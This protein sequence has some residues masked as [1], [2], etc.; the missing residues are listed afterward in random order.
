MPLLNDNVMQGR[1][2]R[3]WLTLSFAVMFTAVFLFNSRV[4]MLNVVDFLFFLPSLTL[5]TRA[6]V[7]G[8]HRLLSS[9][10][11]IPLYALLGWALLSMAWAED[12]NGS[13]TVRAVVQIIAM[14]GLF[15]WLHLY[16]R[17]TFKQ[18]LTNGALCAVIVAATVM[19]SYY[20]TQ[21]LSSPLFSEPANLIFHL[22]SLDPPSALMAMLAP[23]FILLAQAREEGPSGK[24]GRRLAGALVGFAF[25]CLVSLPLG[26]MAV[27][28]GV[29]VLLFGSRHHR[30]SLIPVILA[31]YLLVD[32]SSLDTAGNYLL[33]PWFGNGLNLETLNEVIARQ[34][35]QLLTFSHPRNLFLLLV[36]TVGV[37]GLLLFLACWLVPLTALRQRKIDWSYDRIFT[38]SVL[39]ALFMLFGTG[40]FLL[41]PFQ[42]SWLC[43]WIPM[44]LLLARLSER[45]TIRPTPKR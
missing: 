14:V 28:L 9:P 30:F 6:V 10:L 2:L 8:D 40:A 15:R 24:G 20:T 23:T 27:L 38:A 33:H 39:P 5:V 7:S 1:W 16:Y 41:R 31:L 36:H 43:I 45:D 37:I 22:P 21:P 13:R 35:D 19:V 32:Q 29:A 44:A 25:L 42:S 18:A 11:L 3:W 34:G 26:A 17:H 4:P 12:P